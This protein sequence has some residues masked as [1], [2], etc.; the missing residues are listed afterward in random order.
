VEFGGVLMIV[1]NHLIF[2]NRDSIMQFGIR[3]LPPKK[4][5]TKFILKLLF[6]TIG[7]KIRLKTIDLC[8]LKLII[9]FMFR[10]TQILLVI[11]VHDFVSIQL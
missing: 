6:C 1:L 8:Y 4:Q 3:P 9:N 11:S 10:P 2:D 7:K 5:L